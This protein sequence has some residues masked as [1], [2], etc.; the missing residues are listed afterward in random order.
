MVEYKSYPTP[1]QQ[2]KGKDFCCG[3]YAQ[4]S[5]R[6]DKLVYC[7]VPQFFPRRPVDCVYFIPSEDSTKCQCNYIG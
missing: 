4:T 1:S 7:D 2:R 3:R 5:E 6:S